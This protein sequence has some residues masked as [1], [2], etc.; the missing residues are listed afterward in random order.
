MKITNKEHFIL[1]VNGINQEVEVNPETPLLYVLRNDLGLKSVK[2]GCGSEQCGACK[3]LVDGRAVPTCKL[4]VKNILGMKII[5]VEGLGTPA[6]LHPLQEA[7]IEEQTIQC[8]YCT[9]GIITAAQGLLNRNRYPTDQEIR[10]EVA[11]NLCRCGTLDRV[12]RAIKLRIGKPD[13]GQI[14]EVIEGKPLS[15]SIKEIPAEIGLSIS[16]LANPDLDSWI[17]INNDSTITVLTGKVEIGQGIKTALAQIA[18]EEL[19]VDLN[20]IRMA[21]T[22][23]THSPDEGLTVGSMSIETSGQAIRIAAA[24]ARHLLL[25]IA[26]EELEAPLERLDVHDGTITDPVS[27]RS[28]TYW[29]L[30]G[31]KSFGRQV[32]GIGQPKPPETYQIIGEAVKRL[33]L[34]DKVTG[35]PVFVHDLELPGMVHARVVRPSHYEAS[36]V[37]ADIDQVSRM[38]GVVK[39]IRDGSFLGVIASG[40]DQVVEAMKVLAK[41]AIWEGQANFPSQQEIYNQLLNQPSQAFLVVNGTSTDQPIPAIKIPSGAYET[42]QATYF[43]PYQMHASIGPSAAVA[44]YQDGNLTLWVHSQGVYPIRHAIAAVVGMDEAN[45][46]VI[47]IEGAGCYGHNGTDDAALDAALLARNIEGKPVSLKW[48]REDEMRWEP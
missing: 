9:S 18:A 23:S 32:T 41:S 22:D 11:D 3:V 42:L 47:Q 28:T 5:T 29:D 10:Q 7:F 30:F 48:M 4:P 44:L 20:R 38:P 25:S 14:Y 15:K 39:V 37:S 43:R 12:R 27:G 36:L 2:Y 6:A 35:A 8:G 33:D 34:P 31:G 16:L 1:H 19:D 21:T 24:D 26:F 45:I 13:Q 40:E 46:R 17:Q